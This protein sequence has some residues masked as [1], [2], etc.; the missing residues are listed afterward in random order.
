MD[1]KKRA[2]TV[3]STMEKKK[4]RC[5]TTQVTQRTREREQNRSRL[6]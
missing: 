4:L 1:K 2:L 5:R 3:F 6:I